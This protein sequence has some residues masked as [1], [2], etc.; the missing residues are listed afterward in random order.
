MS[1]PIVRYISPLPTLITALLLVIQGSVVFAANPHTEKEVLHLFEF[2]EDSGCT[3]IRNGSEYPS[4]EARD[5]MEMKYEY[6]RR[7]IGTTEDMIRHI[8]TKSSMTGRIYT[9]RCGNSEIPSADW[10][11]GEL[12]AY[13]AAASS[14]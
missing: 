9:V 3:F 13:R 7:R 10:L 14:H 11:T 5:H 12:E 8:A 1:D 2:I 6:V 4:A